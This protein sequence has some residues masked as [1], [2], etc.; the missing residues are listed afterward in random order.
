MSGN[1]RDYYEVLGVHR[2]ANKEEI[3]NTYR[4]LALQYHPDRNKSPGAE[5]KFKEISEAYA[6]LSDDEKRKRYDTY[7]HVGA[8]EVFRGSEANFDEV[9]KD[10][11]FGGFR[12]I[13]EQIFGGGGRGGF[14][15]ARND[16]FGFGFSFGGGRK[17]GRD[18]I[19][20]VELSLEEVLKGRKDEIELPKLEKCSN[21]GGSGSAP[22]TKPRKCS[23]CNGQG[24][25]RRV[26]SQNRFS[27]FV[28]LEP[29]R[30][31]QGQ[32]EIIDKPCTVCSGS[33]RFKKNKKLKLE[34]PAGVEDGMTLQLQG[35]GEPS[36]N[37][38]AGDLL[39]R[40]HVRPHSIFERL[41]DGHLLYNLNLKFTD[42]ALGTDVKVPTLDGHEKL[43]IPQG[44]QPNTI[45][46]IRG[47]GL[48]HYGN[49]G[50]GDQL[51][52]INVKIPTKLNDRQKLLLKELDK[53][54]RNNGED[55]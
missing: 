6:V 7:G 13:F 50:K 9:F 20:D 47:K 39:I 3:K 36:E 21:C 42:L 22:G 27:T 32:G 31:C 8:E 40:V 14:G 45:L 30:T 34:I 46:N 25:T 12:D 37:G 54:F 51:V 15:S 16:P 53:E 26:Y 19:Y 52:R 29:C 49:Y 35:E 1:K 18:I 10:M 5:E 43:K 33:G 4:K 24:Q 44:T 23:V 55:A 48:P 28:S 2:S 38:I 41:E 11:G 17:K